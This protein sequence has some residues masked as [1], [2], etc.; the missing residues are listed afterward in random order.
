MYMFSGM[1]IWYQI[2]VMDASHNWSIC[3]TDTFYTWILGK[4]CMTKLHSHLSLVD[5]WQG[6]HHWTMCTA[7]HTS[8]SLY[9]VPFLQVEF[10]Y[11]PLVR[12]NA[13]LT[14]TEDT[15]PNGVSL[16]LKPSS[17]WTNNSWSNLST[18]IMECLSYAYVYC[19]VLF[20]EGRIFQHHVL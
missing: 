12:A 15:L 13:H 19:S 1:T 6:F 18:L 3:T 4:C 10:L 2:T 11:V 9:L 8:V 17:T 14:I 16:W 20:N 5:C 7:L